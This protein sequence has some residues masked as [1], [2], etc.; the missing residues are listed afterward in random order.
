MLAQNYEKVNSVSHHS[1]KID[2]DLA[3]SSSVQDGVICGSVSN[4]VHVIPFSDVFAK[5]D[6]DRLPEHRLYDCLIDL[7][8]GVCPPFGPLYVL[9]VPEL[10]ALRVY[11]DE[12]LEQGFI[13]PSKSSVGVPILFVKKKDDSLHLCVDY[14]GLNKLTVRNRYPLPLIPE[15]LDQLCVLRVFSKV[16][17]RRAYN[18]VCI[19][20]GDEWKTVW[21]F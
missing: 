2:S 8:E 20:S 6:A 18:L 21:A 13:Q 9:T 19:K 15:L 11:L 10:K 5:C 17:M 14:W 1:E 4:T 7:Q 3:T 16:D 12:N